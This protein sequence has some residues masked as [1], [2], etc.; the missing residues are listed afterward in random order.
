MAKTRTMSHIVDA[1]PLTNLDGVAGKPW[2]VNPPHM[3]EVEDWIA[4]V[5]RG[6]QKNGR[7]ESSREVCL[8][9]E[10]LCYHVKYFAWFLYM[11]FVSC[12]CKCNIILP[13]DCFLT[14]TPIPLFLT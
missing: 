7:G 4:T 13:E 12:C 5:S 10:N 3:T 9:S 8:I 6:M 11:R 14:L 2:K 1:D